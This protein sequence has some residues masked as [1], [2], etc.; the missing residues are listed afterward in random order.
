MSNIVLLNED[1]TLIYQ[2]KQGFVN[3]LFIFICKKEAVLPKEGQLS[4]SK[5]YFRQA[6]RLLRKLQDVL[7]FAPK[8]YKGTPRGQKKSKTMLKTFE[9]RRFE[10]F[11]LKIY[12]ILFMHCCSCDFFDSLSCPS[13]R[14]TALILFFRSARAVT[15]LER[16]VT[17]RT[18][19]FFTQKQASS[20]R[21]PQ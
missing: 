12:I 11:S 13:E 15:F 2:K 8:A 18:L 20:R 1:Y 6:D 7:F 10:G 5:K 14:K 3:N 16:K 17:K 19:S 9:A 21:E 4:L